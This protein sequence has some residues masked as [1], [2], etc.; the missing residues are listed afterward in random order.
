MGE[1]QNTQLIITDKLNVDI[2]VEYDDNRIK[3]N[4]A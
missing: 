2:C 1:N 3:F 4:V